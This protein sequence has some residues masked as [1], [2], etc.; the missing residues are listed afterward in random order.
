M[1]ALPVCRYGPQCYRK[2]PDHFTSFAHPW[3]D[4]PSADVPTANVEGV[5]PALQSR[6]PDLKMFPSPW[7][8]ADY[9]TGPQPYTLIELVSIRGSSSE[10]CFLCVTSSL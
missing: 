7:D 1:S 4:V 5:F 6:N 9:G 10:T 3:L 2:N 8:E